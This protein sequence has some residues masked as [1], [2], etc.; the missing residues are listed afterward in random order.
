MKDLMNDHLVAAAD[1]GKVAE[2]LRE[3]IEKFIEDEV[4]RLI[5]SDGDPAVIVTQARALRALKRKLESEIALGEA[6]QEALK[7]RRQ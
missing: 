3:Y 7:K 2:K 4:M 5:D 6:A 1:K